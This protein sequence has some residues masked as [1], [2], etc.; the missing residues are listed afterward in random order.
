MNNKRIIHLLSSSVFSGAE[1]VVC[2]IISVLKDDYNF[3]YSSP[4][5]P[6][7][8]TL[9]ER[10][11]EYVPIKALS[12]NSI[13]K[14]IKT[15]NPDIIHAHDIKAGIYASLGA[16][17]TG[18]KL[19]SHVHVNNDNMSR[20]NVKTLLFL[21]ASIRFKHI[22]WVSSSCFD[23]YYFKRCVQKKS[24]VLTNVMDKED[25]IK[26]SKIDTNSVGYD[27]VYVG[28]LTYQKNPERL[29]CVF[30]KIIDMIP[31]VR[32]GVVGNGDMY[33]Q[34]KSMAQ[35]MG[36]DNNV[37]FYGFH[38]YPLGILSKSKV[39]IMTSRFEGLPMSVL[40][41]MALGVPIVSTPV[42]G[43]KDVI[44]SG[45]E[46]FLDDDD[47][48]L[49]SYICRLLNDEE[50]RRELANNAIDKF[51]KICNLSKYKQSIDEEYKK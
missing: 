49:A 32:I 18:V 42:D 40:E 29:L 45:K 27:I 33:E 1:N 38:P 9:E 41:A 50:Y 17:G 10:G 31:D 15:Y 28:R 36:L 7:K 14:I 48:K 35:N 26:R 11:I 23:N 21:I 47:N 16:I 51:D 19:V 30:R 24:S 6:I 22:F 43:L 37:V 34:T 2:Q 25:I 39:M 5:G 46:G 20:F 8:E 4:D 3:I 13:K 12:I 44:C